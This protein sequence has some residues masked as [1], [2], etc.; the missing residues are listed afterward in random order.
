MSIAISMLYFGWILWYGYLLGCLICIMIC[1]CIL[2]LFALKKSTPVT[3]HGR[4]TS[5]YKSWSRSRPAIAV[6]RPLNSQL[7]MGRLGLFPF[8]GGHPILWFHEPCQQKKIY[9]F[10]PNFSAL[11]HVSVAGI[12]ITWEAQGICAGFEVFQSKQGIICMAQN[13]FN[14]LLSLYILIAR[15]VSFSHVFEDCFGLRALAKAGP[16]SDPTR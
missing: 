1:L 7:L 2:I 10:I 8:Q 15:H 11:K 12:S 5:N 4:S 14:G 3:T 13:K 16:P 9:D 6:S